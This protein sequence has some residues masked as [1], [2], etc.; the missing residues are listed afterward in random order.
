MKLSDLI[1]EGGFC[2]DLEATDKEPVIRELV[3]CLIKT[4]R[5]QDA[6][7]KR[8]IKAL[9]DR[10]ELGSTGI[11]S[12]VAVPHAKHDAVT[13]LVCVFGRSTKGINFNAL[14][15][16]PVYVVFLLLSSKGAAGTHLEALAFI[17]RL[18]R[19]EKYVKFLKDAKTEEALRDILD[20]ANHK[21]GS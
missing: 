4:G 9:M 2:P 6:I 14:D 15:G 20:E 3:E 18:V 5:I 1:P 21:F 12:G 16:E 19:D 8:V 11:G 7:S 13:D 10:E 17:S